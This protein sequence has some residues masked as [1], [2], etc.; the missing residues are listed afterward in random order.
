MKLR[1]TEE[2]TRKSR[3]SDGFSSK[4]KECERKEKIK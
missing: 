2:F 4:C 3:N 1:N